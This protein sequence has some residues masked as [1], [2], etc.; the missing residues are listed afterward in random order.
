MVPTHGLVLGK[1]MP[2]RK[3]LFSLGTKFGIKSVCVCMCV[4]GGYFF[5]KKPKSGHFL[6]VINRASVNN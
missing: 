3:W 6:L 5:V 4:G 1:N 2:L